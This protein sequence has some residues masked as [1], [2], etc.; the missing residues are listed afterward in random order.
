[1]LGGTGLIG[2]AAFL[3]WTAFTF[4]LALRTAKKAENAGE[5]RLSDLAYGIFTALIL[6]HVN[7]M[8]NVTFWEGKVM[9]QQM[10]GVSILLLI[11]LLH[12][13]GATNRIGR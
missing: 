10:L 4:Q 8:T 7:G 9:H 6:L 3:I 1:M 12:R 13:R 2:T 11:D 5:H